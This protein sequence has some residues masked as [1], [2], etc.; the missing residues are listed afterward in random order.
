MTQNQEVNQF[1]NF[2]LGQVL[3]SANDSPK[4]HFSENSFL[5]KFNSS[6]IASHINPYML[7]FGNI[8]QR[9]FWKK[10][11]RL[12]F[13]LTMTSR[14][15]I[16]KWRHVILK[17]H[18]RRYLYML[19]RHTCDVTNRRYQGLKKNYTIFP[20]NDPASFLEKKSKPKIQKF[21]FHEW[22]WVT[23]RKPLFKK[24]VGFLFQKWRWVI[25]RV[26]DFFPRFPY[27]G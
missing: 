8:T 10:N 24:F 5:R 20:G 9:H 23:P 13:Y 25:P 3:I 11:P 17:L 26:L 16:I 19:W 2:C 22:R 6:K 27:K 18:P 7:H 21:F 14:I 15:A 4:I 12:S 1:F